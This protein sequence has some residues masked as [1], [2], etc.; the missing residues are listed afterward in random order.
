MTYPD[1]ELP[2]RRELGQALTKFMSEL[3]AAGLG[4]GEMDSVMRQIAT[5]KYREAVEKAAAKGIEVSM[6]WHTLGVWTEEG[7]ERIGYFSRALDCIRGESAATPP[8]TDVEKWS[9]VHTEADCLFEIG[10]IHAH[11]GLPEVA[12]QFLSEA[13][14]LAQKADT[15]RPAAKTKDDRLEGR[16]A[17]LLLQLPDENGE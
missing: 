2:I 11:E 8:K 6:C 14:P 4:T 17:E 15:L 3:I 5:E 10:R 7:K 12:R 13:L 16:I 9:A 1:H